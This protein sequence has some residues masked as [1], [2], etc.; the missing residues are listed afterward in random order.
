M[1]YFGTNFTR[2]NT[3]ASTS[4]DN[5]HSNSKNAYIHVQYLEFENA[6]LKKEVMTLE[7]QLQTSK[8]VQ[9]FGWSSH[10]M[11]RILF[12]EKLLERLDRV[13]RSE[14]TRL[15]AFKDIPP[16]LHQKDYQKVTF[17][18]EVYDDQAKMAVSHGATLY[19]FAI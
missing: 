5:N 13:P 19:V 3:Y 11:I 7:A 8:W 14:S 10:M 16:P 18:S 15:P 4:V 6:R 17:W 12:Q 9:V 2:H 1:S